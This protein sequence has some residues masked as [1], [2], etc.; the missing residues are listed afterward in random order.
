VRRDIQGIFCRTG[1]QCSTIGIMKNCTVLGV[2]HQQVHV[3]ST[4]HQLRVPAPNIRLFCSGE[5]DAVKACGTEEYRTVVLYLYLVACTG[6]SSIV[7]FDLWL[8]RESRRLWYGAW[9]GVSYLRR[10]GRRAKKSALI[11]SWRRVFRQSNH[12]KWR[13]QTLGQCLRDLTNY[14]T[15]PM[16][17]FVWRFVKTCAYVRTRFTKQTTSSSIY[18]HVAHVYQLL[19]KITTLVD[20]CRNQRREFW[21]QPTLTH[22]PPK[23]IE[24]R[25]GFGLMASLCFGNSDNGPEIMCYV[26]QFLLKTMVCLPH[27]LLRFN[28]EDLPICQRCY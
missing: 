17:R 13:R 18:D 2:R 7:V 11:A 12:G 4:Q 1:I 14:K 16:S 22:G 23:P 24:L 9:P 5:S 21:T 15:N 27:R 6:P 3:P 28:Q 10:P 20:L 25:M 26:D 19:P 8:H